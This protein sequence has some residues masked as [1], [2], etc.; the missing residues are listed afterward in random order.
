ME[1]R[2]TEALN[3]EV[4]DAAVHVVAGFSEDLDG[5]HPLVKSTQRYCDRIPKLIAQHKRRGNDAWRLTKEEDRPP[6]DKQGRYSFL[7]HG[8]MD[9]RASRGTMD[10]VL[11][12]SR[13][14]LPGPGGRRHGDRAPRSA[15]GSSDQPVRGP[16]HR[17]P[18]QGKT[19]TI[20]FSQVHRRVHLDD[21][22]LAKRKKE[23][24]WAYWW[25]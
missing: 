4:A 18:I 23:D 22:E 16:G 14:D 12:F 15:D 11:R 2:R 21:D 17:G 24:F 5:A 3:A 13:L 25:A 8:P 9:I 19:F 6:S 10:W 1:R 20:Q 7:H